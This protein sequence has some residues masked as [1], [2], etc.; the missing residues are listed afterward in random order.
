MCVFVCVH[1]H[2][3]M[4][5]ATCEPNMWSILRSHTVRGTNVWN[6]VRGR[7]R[8]VD[9]PRECNAAATPHLQLK[10]LATHS[11]TQSGNR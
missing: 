9:W 4:Y 1:G 11:A 3:Q 10:P 8:R 5:P 6:F 2:I 7:V